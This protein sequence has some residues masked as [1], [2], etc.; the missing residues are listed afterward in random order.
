M[1]VDPRFE[2]D[3]VDEQE[4]WRMLDQR[5]GKEGALWLR[6]KDVFRT[7]LVSEHASRRP[8]TQTESRMLDAD[9]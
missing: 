4:G 6:R 7:T 5:V 8:L 2:E 3:E 1:T 9:L